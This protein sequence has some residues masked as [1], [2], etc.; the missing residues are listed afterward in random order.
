[1]C[2]GGPGNLLS[3]CLF[4]FGYGELYFGQPGKRHITTLAE[5][6]FHVVDDELSSIEYCYS[7]GWTDGLPVVPPTED[8][9]SAMIAASGRRADQALAT[10]APT[11]RVCTVHAAAVNAVMAGCRPKYF[12]IVVAALEAADRDR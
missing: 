1:L 7:Q 6:R 5:P 8:A 10:H 9:V 3:E 2:P 11:G 4:A 12:P